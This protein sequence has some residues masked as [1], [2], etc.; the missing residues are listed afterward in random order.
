MGIRPA[1]LAARSAAILILSMTLVSPAAAQ[2]RAA[3]SKGDVAGGWS[4]TFASDFNVP[5]GWLFAIAMRAGGPGVFVVGEAQGHYKTID[6]F[7]D[8]LSASVHGFL[9]GVRVAP[10]MNSKVQGFFQALAGM[11]RLGASF[12]GES[13]SF[14]KFALQ[15]GGGVDVPVGERLFLRLQADILLVF[16]GEENGVRAGTSRDFRVGVSIGVPIGA[17]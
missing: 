11:A 2:T 17:R 4:A 9:G 10:A 1:V 7:G 6:F 13:A 8:D 15:P 12:A 5:T 14:T 16:F 3:D